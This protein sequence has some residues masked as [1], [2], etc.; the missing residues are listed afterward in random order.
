VFGLEVV[1]EGHGGRLIQAAQREVESF[2]DQAEHG[3]VRVR[4]E[5]AA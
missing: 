5:L 2:G 1:E 3:D 4:A